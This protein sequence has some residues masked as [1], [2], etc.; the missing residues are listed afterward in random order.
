MTKTVK[1]IIII[2]IV[3]VLS[4][5][6]VLGGIF[7]ARAAE[8]NKQKQAERKAIEERLG[9]VDS[10]EKGV[11]GGINENWATDLTSSEIA[12]LETAGDYVVFKGWADLI[13]DVLFDSNLQTAKIQ[14]LAD[15]INSEQGKKLFANFDDNAALIIPLLRQ[16]GFTSSDIATLV[17]S[18]LCAFV[19]NGSGALSQMKDTL[20]SI[21]SEVA[22]TNVNKNLAAVNT[23]L[24]YLT[25]TEAEKQE[26]LSALADA[27]G[28]IK[29]LASFAYTTSINTLTDNMIEIIASDDGALSD[30]TDGEIQ[31]VVN[32]MLQNVR[33]L[34]TKMTAEEIGKL[35][36]A[37][38]V[39]TSKFDGNL[40]TSGVFA[41]IVEYAKYAYIITDSIPYFSGITIAAANVVD[42]NFLG[43][44][45]EYVENEP[46]YD[47]KLKQANI[48]VIAAKILKSTFD[49]VDRAELDGLID[50]LEIQAK[51]DYRR[52][53][54]L[55]GIDFY[56]N[57][58]AYNSETDETIHPTI[59]S[60]DVL[61]DV[62]AYVIMYGLLSK[63]ES[64]YYAY[65][66]GKAT[67]DDLRKAANNCP[68]DKFGIVNPYSRTDDTR[69]WFEYYMSETS[70][71]LGEIANDLAPT[72]KA[73]LIQCIDDYCAENSVVKEKTELLASKSLIEPLAEGATDE[74]QQA[75]QATVDEYIQLSVD[76]RVYGLGFLIGGF[77]K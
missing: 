69:R 57:I 71:K 54:P 43:V 7:G 61:E 70:A 20:V 26:I 16:V 15:A 33:D 77:F 13:A 47:D 41:Q 27:E 40:T 18:L 53:L 76:A 23:E 35:N 39:V 24:A 31:T 36:R 34:K 14:A 46:N 22:A 55:V 74:Q 32:A 30:V 42:V 52:A 38:E 4:A 58:M 9:A 8:A 21:K 68:F 3:L 66:D 19:E 62:V 28:A 11:L 44:V 56:I 75:Y 17:Y 1:I 6:A 59:I 45:R 64:T 73:D 29:E 60:E 51:K 5:G 37:I 50:T 12:K 10:V 63:L 72:L 67:D 25:F 2:A 49:N 65:L 48:S